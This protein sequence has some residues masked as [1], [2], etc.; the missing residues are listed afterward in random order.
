MRPLAPETVAAYDHRLEQ[1]VIPRAE[2]GVFRRWIQCYLDFC[3]KYQ[4]PPREAGSVGPF[5]MKLAAKQQPE[6]ARRQAA[7]AVELSLAG[8]GLNRRDVE[9]RGMGE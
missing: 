5:L 8:R 2:R 6:Q 3:A 9:A 1:A 7:R 4:Y